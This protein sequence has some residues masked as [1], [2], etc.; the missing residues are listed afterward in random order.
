MVL[1]TLLKESDIEPSEYPKAI[2]AL[3]MVLAATGW[4][5]RDLV[6]IAQPLEW[7]VIG[8]AG[9]VECREY[10]MFKKRTEVGEVV[11]WSAITDAR[12][13]EPTLRVY[14]L[15]VKIE[16]ENAPRTY[17]WSGESHGLPERDRVFHFISGDGM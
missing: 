3:E 2:A 5:L 10:G 17:T 12:Q 16:G 14:G 6:S 8:K 15:E 4:G 9:L 1:V 13:T 7:L 11:P